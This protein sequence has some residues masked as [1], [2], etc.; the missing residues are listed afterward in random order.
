MV[1]ENRESRLPKKSD[2]YYH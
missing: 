1:F 2:G